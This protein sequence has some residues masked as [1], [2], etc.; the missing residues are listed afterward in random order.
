M[1]IDA[2]THS[3][4]GVSKAAGDLLVQEYGRYFGL[5]TACFRGGCLTGPGHSGAPL[6]GFLSYLVRCAVLGEPYTVLGYKGKQMRDNLHAHDLVSA[7]WHFFQAPRSG[8]VYNMG[9]A[10]HSHCSM[11]EAIAACENMTGRPM[12][13]SYSD[14]NRI[15]D[16]VWWISDVSR[17]RTDYPEWRLTYDINRILEE[18]HAAMV[19]RLATCPKGDRT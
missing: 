15:G 2:S 9:G 7:F 1:S 6:H 16:H 4:F 19:E 17:F 13:W 5:K 12:N 14:Q 10:R 3:L 18:I 11:L 8:V